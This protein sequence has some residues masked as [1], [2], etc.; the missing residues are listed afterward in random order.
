MISRLVLKNFQCHENQEFHLTEGV[1]AFI[2]ESD[3]GKSAVLRAL[4]W[5]AL[6]A[7]SGDAFIRHDEDTAIVIADVDD[8]K[9]L[10]KKGKS[11]NLYKLDGTVFKSFGSGKVPDPI[12]QLLQVDD[13]NFQRQHDAP[14]WLSLSPGQASKELNSVVD[15]GAIDN[16]LFNVASVLRKAK[17]EVEIADERLT[18]AKKDL[19][20]TADIPRISS[21][22]KELEQIAGVYVEKRRIAN[23]LQELTSRT[24]AVRTELKTLKLLQE[25]GGAAVQAGEQCREN[26]QRT[27]RLKTIIEQIRETE[28]QATREIPAIEPLEKVVNAI[29]ENKTRYRDASNLTNQLRL[30]E[31]E[32]CEL[33]KTSERLT[34][35]LKQQSKGKCPTCGKSLTP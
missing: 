30:Q 28:H 15:L 2:G 6:N 5:L 29:A 16:A 8:R 1:N 17:L 33:T 21:L 14:F 3:K 27:A 13:L 11:K 32:L 26:N 35:E 23:D 7:P 4:R 24:I 12:A 22:Y 34:K 25:T 31:K 9:I 20:E 18:A 19:A 10:R